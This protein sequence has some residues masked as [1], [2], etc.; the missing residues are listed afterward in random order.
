MLPDL[1]VVDPELWAIKNPER[2]WYI[3]SGS[4]EWHNAISMIMRSV[5]CERTLAV[6]TKISVTEGVTDNL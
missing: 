3:E 1:E 2:L 4:S 5:S 6:L